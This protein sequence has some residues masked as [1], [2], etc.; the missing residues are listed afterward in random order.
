MTAYMEQAGACGVVGKAQRKLPGQYVQ[1]L[2]DDVIKAGPA[3]DDFVPT[4]GTQVALCTSGTTATSRIFVYDEEAICNQVLNSELLHKMN[5]RIISGVNERS[6][7]FLPYHHVFGFV[8]N[9]LWSNFIGYESVFIK[10][11]TPET[12]L[13]TARRFRITILCAVPL[14]ANNLSVGL[15]KKVA[16]QGRKKRAAFKFARGLSLFAVYRTTFGMD[17]ARNVLLGCG[18]AD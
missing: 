2:L 1:V 7:A 4:F 9:L 8:V 12:I 18:A 13:S 10:D 5:P 15:N 17:F 6:L 14:L 16:Q 3:P 11:R